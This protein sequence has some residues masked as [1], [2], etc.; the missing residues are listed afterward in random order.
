MILGIAPCYQ[1]VKVNRRQ[2]AK[3][4][5]TKKVECFIKEYEIKEA[6]T[7]RNIVKKNL[8]TPITKAD[9]LERRAWG[10]IPSSVAL[11]ETSYPGSHGR[12]EPLFNPSSST[13][14]TP[15]F[16]KI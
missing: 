8:L 15:R 3:R 12:K 7:R 2:R 13:G 16:T 9:R 5:H 10:S 14:E 4:A 1:E 11:V 6:Q